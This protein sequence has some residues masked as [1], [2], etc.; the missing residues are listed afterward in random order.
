MLCICH[1]VYV[2]CSLRKVNPT[3]STW[4]MASV[5]RMTITLKKQTGPDNW[6]RL[7]KGKKKPNNIHF[8]WE[9]HEKH[10]KELEALEDADE[11]GKDPV[12]KPPATEAEDIEKMSKGGVTDQ[13]DSDVTPDNSISTATETSSE[14]TKEDEEGSDAAPAKPKKEKKKK[15]KKEKKDKKSKKP[16]L[17]DLV[18]DLEKAGKEL[19]KDVDRKA[20]LDKEAINKDTEDKIKDLRRDFYKTNKDDAKEGAEISTPPTPTDLD[21]LLPDD[22]KLESES[23]T[24]S[25]MTDAIKGEL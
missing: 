12:V 9:L 20:K 22:T 18:K 7:T 13:Q 8:W 5:G 10:A 17:D 3:E 2:N 19:K 23:T 11:D 15:V 14:K 25:T 4:S 24:E 1:P 21:K 6:V 16:T